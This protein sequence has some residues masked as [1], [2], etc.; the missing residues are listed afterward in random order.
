MTVLFVVMVVAAE[1]TVAL[2][3][4]AVMFLVSKTR[5]R[6]NQENL[7][8]LMREA[9][10]VKEKERKE[11]WEE[12]VEKNRHLL[13]GETWRDPDGKA[14]FVSALYGNN[15]PDYL[16]YSIGTNIRLVSNEDGGGVQLVRTIELLFFPNKI[17]DFGD[18][19]FHY[20]NYSEVGLLLR[21][22]NARNFAI[23]I[24]YYGSIFPLYQVGL[25]EMFDQL[26]C[27]NFLQLQGTQIIEQKNA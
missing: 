4:V 3:P 19:E 5:S 21:V 10:L 1:I 26:G 23:E 6:K 24:E 16:W 20:S 2:S 15:V 14:Y 25:S 27:V 8:R 7:D 17:P 9:Y 18:I 11:R 13:T 22:R 12:R